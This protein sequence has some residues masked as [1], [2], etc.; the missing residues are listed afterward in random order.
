MAKT[1]VFHGARAK[2]SVGSVPVGIFTNV[3]FQYTIEDQEVGILGRFGP[4]EIALVGAQA[5]SGQLSGWRVIGHG[6][7][8]AQFKDASG[9]PAKLVPMLQDLLNAEE[10]TI[11]L[12]DRQTGTVM[13]NVTGVK[14]LGMST[15]AQMRQLSDISIPFKGTGFSEDGGPA[16]GE[17]GAMDLP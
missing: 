8:A 3:S 7:F 16:S 12:T 6:G 14:T 1:K 4:V 13:F 2:V 11:T 5:I 15:G 10:T 17:P 9:Q